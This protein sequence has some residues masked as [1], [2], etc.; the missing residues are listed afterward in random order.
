MV[1]GRRVG[2]SAAHAVIVNGFDIVPDDL[3]ANHHRVGY[4]RPVA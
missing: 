2:G 4:F 1:K 3:A